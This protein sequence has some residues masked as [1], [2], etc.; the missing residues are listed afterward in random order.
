MAAID[1]FVEKA[2]SKGLSDVEIKQKLSEAGWQPAQIDAAV[3][4]LQVPRPGN[5]AEVPPAPSP[6][7]QPTQSSEPIAVVHNLSVRG[8]EYSIMFIALWATAFALGSL[9]HTFVS[10]VFSKASGDYYYGSVD[11][12]SSFMIT[13][14]IVCF[15]IFIYLF[16]RLKRAEINDPK[17]LDDP[18]RRRWSQLTQ[19]VTFL[20]GLGY[21]IHF[22]YII[23]TPQNNSYNYYGTD[24]SSS[25]PSIGVQF[26]H[27]LVT[28][29]IAGSIFAYYWRED[30]HKI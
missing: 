28:L 18:S 15:P 20:V 8:F 17:L 24:V 25:G 9:A 5:D 29:V 22:V 6:L 10:N 27:V 26:L 21:I 3:D 19:L 4:D 16:L 23:I 12:A 14:L 11:S 1:Q 2:R 30:H 7:V 13:L